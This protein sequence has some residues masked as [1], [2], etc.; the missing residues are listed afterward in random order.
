MV[1]VRPK[2]GRGSWLEFAH[3]EANIAEGYRAGMKAL[4]EVDRYFEQPGGIFPRRRFAITVDRD[5][6][7]G[8]GLCPALAPTLMGLDSTGKAFARTTIVDWSPAD[9]DF[10]HHCPTDAIVAT[11]LDRNATPT[12]TQSVAPE[13]P[14][15]L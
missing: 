2:I 15:V 13:V 14:A 3:T 10:V 11:K 4:E 8:C 7:T 6:C 12:E 5:R 9:G 1:L